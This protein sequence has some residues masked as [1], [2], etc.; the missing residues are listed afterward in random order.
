V[1]AEPAHTTQHNTR[2]KVEKEPSTSE[3]NL[4]RFCCRMTQGKAVVSSFCLASNRW[5]PSP[6]RALACCCSSFF[7][8][9]SCSLSPCPTEGNGQITLPKLF[10]YL[11][12]RPLPTHSS[13]LLSP[14]CLRPIAQRFNLFSLSTQSPLYSIT[15]SALAKHIN[16]HTRKSPS[17]SRGGFLGANSNIANRADQ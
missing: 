17:P 11:S 12:I 10:F 4:L 2:L 3:K 14:F 9:F 16:N 15:H 13:S 5:H 8:W 1:P 6:L 7:G